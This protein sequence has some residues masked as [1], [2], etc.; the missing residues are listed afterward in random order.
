ASLLRECRLNLQD[1]L[2]LASEPQHSGSGWWVRFV[3][4]ISVQPSKP[5]TWLRPIGATA[6][7]AL[8]FFGARLTPLLERGNSAYGSLAV[9][10]SASPRVR[11]VEPAADG[12]IQIVLDETRQRTVT[13]ALEDQGIRS[14]LLAAAKDPS[15]PSLRYETLE[16]LSARGQSA[17]IRDALL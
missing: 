2:E 12:R 13:G 10:G 1:R 16:I 14:L 7:I 15:D 11:F 8:G 3:N 6:L 17:D 9:T 4:S 5:A